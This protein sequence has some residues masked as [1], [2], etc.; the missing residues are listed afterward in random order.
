MIFAIVRA[1]KSQDLVGIYAAENLEALR[2]LVD[3][4]ST[5]SKC[6]YTT[7]EMGGIATIRRLD[8]DAIAW[9]LTAGLS[10]LVHA[11]SETLWAPLDPM[12][13]SSGSQLDAL[14][15]TEEG[16]EA[17]ARAFRASR[18]ITLPGQAA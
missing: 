1:I 4:T 9:R 8:E 7:P 10:E 16:C 2:A 18:S 12:I 5:P 17:I 11:R 3:E 15:E 14:L 6:E 13:Q